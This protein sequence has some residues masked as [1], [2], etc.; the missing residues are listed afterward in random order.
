MSVGIQETL[1]IHC[2]SQTPIFVE[3]MGIELQKRGVPV[4]TPFGGLGCHVDAMRFISH[5]PQSQYPAASLAAAI[6]LVGGIRGM[7]RGTLSEARNVDGSEHLAAMELVRLAV[8]KRVFSLSH[9]KFVGDRV[10]W[11][12]ENR[13][14]IGGLSFEEEPA[15][16]RFFL[17]RLKPVGNWQEAIRDKFL[18]EMPTGV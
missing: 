13:H 16:L 6:Y 2:I 12:Y 3:A 8:P 1:D 9:M 15:T 4:V 11:L 7:E 18:E 17:G 10:G 14:L 5:V